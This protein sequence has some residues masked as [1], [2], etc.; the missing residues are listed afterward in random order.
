[1]QAIRIPDLIILRPLSTGFLHTHRFTKSRTDLA[2]CPLH[3]SMPR[4]CRS[5]SF[6]VPPPPPPWTRYSAYTWHPPQLYVIIGGTI[7]LAASIALSL[8]FYSHFGRVNN[9]VKLKAQNAAEKAAIILETARR[10]AIA[11][12]QLNDYIAH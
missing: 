1:M 10:Q 8:W 11:E 2:M 9:L 7:I 5:T 6:N 4:G 12:R 3:P